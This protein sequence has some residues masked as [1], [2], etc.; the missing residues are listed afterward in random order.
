MLKRVGVAGAPGGGCRCSGLECSG[1]GEDGFDLLV[2]GG[3]KAAL[4]AGPYLQK[5]GLAIFRKPF[6]LFGRCIGEGGD[7]ETGA[8]GGW[9]RVTGGDLGNLVAQVRL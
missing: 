1:V 4:A 3:R 6:D 9:Q 5:R 8:F 2:F 7:L